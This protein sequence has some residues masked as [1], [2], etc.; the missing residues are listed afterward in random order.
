[1][2]GYPCIGIPLYRDGPIYGYP[3]IHTDKAILRMIRAL[4]V[5][6]SAPPTLPYAALTLSLRFLAL[7]LAPPLRRPCAA[8]APPV[9]RPCAALAPA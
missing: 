5:R 1:M 3:Y 6:G 8:L 4:G 7:L 9:R 2:Y